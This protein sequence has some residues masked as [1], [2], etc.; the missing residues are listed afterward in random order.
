MRILHRDRDEEFWP[1]YV[2]VM[3]ITG[4]ILVFVVVALIIIN[5]ENFTRAEMLRRQQVIE[6][7]F[8]RAMPQEIERGDLKI[9]Q[10]GERQELTFNDRILFDPASDALKPAGIAAMEKV[11]KVLYQNQ[12]DTYATIQVNG[13]TD[14][15]PI[16]TAQFRSNWHLSSSRATTVVEFLA[17]RKIDK[18]VLSATG[19]AEFRPVDKGTDDLAKSR[20]RRIEIVLLY[21]EDFIAE[22]LKKRN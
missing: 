5:T 7:A 10:N 20:N 11:S 15:D 2:D 18:R 3:M 13:H 8:E 12:D 22:S 4:L 19:F 6:K 14:F 1:A 16:A 21:P 17:A 9:E